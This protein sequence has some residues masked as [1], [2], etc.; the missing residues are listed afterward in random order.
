[1][2]H[3]VATHTPVKRMQ[4][5]AA[6]QCRERIQD[7]IKHENSQALEEEE[8]LGMQLYHIKSSEVSVSPDATCAKSSEFDGTM[9]QSSEASQI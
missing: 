6:K 5:N 9:C 2:D 7:I 8:D 3:H 1:M 4:R